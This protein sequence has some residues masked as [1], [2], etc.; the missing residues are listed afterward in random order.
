MAPR[1]RGG[2]RL[3]RNQGLTTNRLNSSSLVTKNGK[4]FRSLRAFDLRQALPRKAL[5]P[6]RLGPQCP[7]QT[8]L[9]APFTDD[10]RQVRDRSRPPRKTNVGMFAFGP[11]R[12]GQER[13]ANRRRQRDLVR[14]PDVA[15]V[16]DG[17]ELRTFQRSAVDR[18]LSTV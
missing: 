3:E 16:Q 6:L 17:V 11:P 4:C 1:A 9:D 10:P 13:C 15:L 18:E 2:R 5:E 7:T 14:L 12:A 8:R